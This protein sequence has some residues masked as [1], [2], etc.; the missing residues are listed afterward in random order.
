MTVNEA[1]D[2]YIKEKEKTASTCLI[3]AYMDCQRKCFKGIKDVPVDKLTDELIQNWINVIGFGKDYKW[4]RTVY[5]FLS[6]A[7]GRTFN[8][9]YDLC[10][11]TSRL[12]RKYQEI[13]KD[14]DLMA[15]LAFTTDDEEYNI[16]GI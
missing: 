12:P 9:N 14:P 2:N 13:V 11:K 8:I 1:L 6:N 15:R 16:T 4:T 7:T 5:N 3:R 10:R